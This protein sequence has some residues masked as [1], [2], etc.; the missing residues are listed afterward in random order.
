MVR[1]GFI[2]QYSCLLAFFFCCISVMAQPAQIQET[3]LPMDVLQVCPPSPS[4]SQYAPF[5]ASKFIIGEIVITGNRKTKA[6]IIERE[7]T[8]KSGDSVLLPDLVKQ[9]EFARTQ[10]YNTR[11][12]NEIIVSL[13]SFHGFVVDIQIDVKERWYIFPVPYL[14]PIDRNLSAWADKGYSVD[15]VNY[16]LKLSWNNLTGRNDKLRAWLITG[17]TQQMQ[18]AYELPYIDKALKQGLGFNVSYATQKE[19]NT[20]TIGNTQV[21]LN[22]DSIDYAGKYL[23]YNFNSSVSWYYRPGILSRHMV[24][25]GYSIS[26]VDSA[27]IVS[28]PK[29]FNKPQEVVRYPEFTYNWEYNKID[30]IA[31]PQKGMTAALEFYKR[32]FSPEMNLWQFSAKTTNAWKFKNRFSY[33]LNF[34]G[35]LKLPFDQ[36]FFNQRLMGF[37][38]YYLRGYEKYVID[39][40][41]SFIIRNTMRKEILNF[42]VPN[43]RKNSRSTIPFHVFAKVYTDIGYAKS[44]YYIPSSLNNRM[45]YTWGAGV[46]VVTL[47]DLVFRFEYSMN[48]LGE[49]G[50]F[51]HLRNDF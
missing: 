38:D 40:V 27:V 14:K 36:P 31:Y 10:L 9:F 13:K 5:Q 22:A 12:F 17:Y 35:V 20:N 45:L 26:K 24:R 8:F 19:L 11:L 46:D 7:L 50:F 34:G 51:F 33:V 30:Y 43:F 2:Y 25:I 39:G 21:F 42:D 48:Q 41:A 16:G 47:Y 44:Q 49:S 28:N 3:S 29:Y 18:L 23:S 1:K 37:G 32:G 15:R 4:D 6:Y